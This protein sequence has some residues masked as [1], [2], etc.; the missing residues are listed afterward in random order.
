VT[1]HDSVALIEGVPLSPGAST[2]ADLGC[3]DGTFTLA[4]ATR[5]PNGSGIHAMDQ[6]ASALARLPKSRTGTS[7]VTHTGD[8]TVHPWPFSGLDGLLLANSLH[9][10][11]D[12]AAFIRACKP[13][14]RT[15][16]FLIVEYD[17]DDAN[18]WVPY[19]LGRRTLEEL[20]RAA[21]Y[22]SFSMLGSRPSVSQRAA[23]YAATI[24]R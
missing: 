7:I 21:G 10:I 18:R 12:Q 9:Y 1:S 23:L 11:R 5:L 15:P 19:P 16:R 4:L 2:W 8:F 3:G 14:M 6:R 22:T 20:F 13:A 24:T 17:T